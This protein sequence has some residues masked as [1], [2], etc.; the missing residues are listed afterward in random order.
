MEQISTRLKELRKKAGFTQEELGRKVGVQKAAVQKWE[1]GRVVNLKRSTMKMLADIFGV[2]ATYLVGLEEGK[3]RPVSLAD[4]PNAYPAD[5]SD[6]V[7]VPIIGSVKAGPD[8]LAFEDHSG[9]LSVDSRYVNGARYF[10]LQVFGDSM[11]GEGI[12]PGDMALVRE[13]SEVNSGDLAVVVVED[14]ELEG[15]IKRVYYNG[16]SIILQSSNPAYPPEVF[17]GRDRAKVRIVGKVK[18]TFRSY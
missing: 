3:P 17:S 5:L 16:K 6:L 2:P 11:I 9:F 7:K 10:V 13:Q 4:L 18:K 12:M 15:R 14:A 8:G 1:S